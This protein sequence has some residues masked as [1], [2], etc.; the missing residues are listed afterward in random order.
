MLQKK[1][2]LD[3]K[4]PCITRFHKVTS[5]PRALSIINA[6]FSFKKCVCGVFFFLKSL[7]ASLTDKILWLW[8]RDVIGILLP[9]FF[10]IIFQTRFLP[11]S[12]F[13]LSYSIALWMLRSEEE[14]NLLPLSIKRALWIW[15]G[16]TIQVTSKGGESCSNEFKF[17]CDQFNFRLEVRIGWWYLKSF[18]DTALGIIQCS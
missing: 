6:Y 10:Y 7:L 17:P 14:R 12:N 11:K 8:D 3:T 16:D 9:R 18:E 13:I 5:W 1:T 2:Q 15:T 4:E